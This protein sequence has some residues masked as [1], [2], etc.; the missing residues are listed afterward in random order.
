M[1]EKAF[2]SVKLSLKRSRGRESGARRRRGVSAKATLECVRRAQLQKAPHSLSPPSPHSPFSPRTNRSTQRSSNSLQH[3]QTHAATHTL[4]TTARKAIRLDP[5][6]LLRP[7]SAASF[8]SQSKRATWLRSRRRPRREGTGR[9]SST[10]RPRTRAFAQRCV[11][12]AD[13]QQQRGLRAVIAS[14]SAFCGSLSAARPQ[15][16]NGERAASSKL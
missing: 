1:T 11:R 12:E 15:R 7:L 2:V 14:F 5:P 13:V 10:C 4:A 3:T 8:R 9:R 16:D 6:H